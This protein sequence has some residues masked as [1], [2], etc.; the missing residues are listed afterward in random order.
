[1]VR[2]SIALET[3]HRIENHHGQTLAEHTF[4][5][6]SPRGVPIWIDSRYVNA[7]LKITTGLI[8]PH[9]MAGF[10]GGRKL[11]CPGLAAARKQSRNPGAGPRRFSNIPTADCNVLARQSRL[12]EENTWITFTCGHRDFIVNVVIDAEHARPLK[13]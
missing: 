11:V 5:G 13:I 7:D 6:D 4:L 9:L 1:M 10:S 2:R 8:E 12:H 3:I